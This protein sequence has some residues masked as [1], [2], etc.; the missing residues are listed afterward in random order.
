MLGDDARG[1]GDA[2][3]DDAFVFVVDV[4]NADALGGGG[5]E[6][7]GG[8]GFR[9]GGEIVND[10]GA[11]VAEAAA[12][13]G[14]HAG[15]VGGAGEGQGKVAAKHVEKECRGRAGLEMG[16]LPSFRGTGEG[17]PAWCPRQDRVESGAEA[18]TRCSLSAMRPWS[19]V[20][21]S[22]L[23]AACTRE[24]H[25][26]A[27]VV[28]TPS[29]SATPSA[30]PSVSASAAPDASGGFDVLD[31]GLGGGGGLLA[32]RP[33]EHVEPVD[34]T[35][36]RMVHARVRFEDVKDGGKVPGALKGLVALKQRFYLCY[37]DALSRDPS[38]EG[39]LTVR[40]NVS[41]DGVV[42]NPM[43][44]AAGV[45]ETV[46]ACIERHVQRFDPGP[47]KGGDVS[48]TI[49]LEHGEERP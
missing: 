27:S 20:M 5:A 8:L 1:R 13:D 28:A 19:L 17:E 49:K 30:A 3:E 6:E 36:A 43:V 14:A 42:S 39:K 40:L 9:E 21:V 41:A 47:T 2:A 37:A 15:E 4:T 7:G 25:E 18:L 33:H 46:K 11:V 31:G 22:S 34:Q 10:A 45:P 48:A 26:S 16:N 38:L 12:G 35:A 23:L 44:T 32:P 24:R 29:V